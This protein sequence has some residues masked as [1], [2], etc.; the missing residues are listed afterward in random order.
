MLKARNRLLIVLAL[1]VL[2]MTTVAAV[3]SATIYRDFDPVTGS[4]VITP[5]TGEPDVTPGG[6]KTAAPRI[7][8]QIAPTPGGSPAIPR[9]L[10][11]EWAIRIWTATHLGVRF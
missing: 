5:S 10:W 2:G 3:S 9:G 8:T 11:F 7:G 1:I 4:P 6:S